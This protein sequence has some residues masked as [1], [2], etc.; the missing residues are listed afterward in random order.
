MDYFH[1][2]VQDIL[3]TGIHLKLKIYTKSILIYKL[4]AFNAVLKT[5]KV[6]MYLI[7]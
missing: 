6:L 1:L 3:L 5:E 7:T 4:K 2:N